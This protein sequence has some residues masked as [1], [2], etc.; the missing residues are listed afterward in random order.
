MMN[1]ELCDFMVLLDGEHKADFESLEDAEAW[2]YLRVDCKMAEACDVV[3][4]WTGEV[5]FH[6]HAETYRVVKKGFDYDE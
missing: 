3:N 5:M 2:G 1:F 6:C 4:R